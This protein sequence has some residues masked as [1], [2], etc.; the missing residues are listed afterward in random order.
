[1]ID[2]WWVWIYEFN[3]FT[4]FCWCV[5]IECIQVAVEADGVAVEEP[6]DSLEEIKLPAFGVP[7]QAFNSEYK[8][9]RRFPAPLPPPPPISSQD[10]ETAARDQPADLIDDEWRCGWHHW[11]CHTFS[12]VRIRSGVIGHVGLLLFACHHDRGYLVCSIRCARFVIDSF[13]QS[14]T[15]E[16][17]R[18]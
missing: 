13:V 17:R 16:R 6:A 3:C 9:P 1:M 10:L 18:I 7:H 8:R 12:D 4:V 15:S 2:Y 11:Q 5:V 14:H